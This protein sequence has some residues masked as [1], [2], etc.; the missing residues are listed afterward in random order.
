MRSG[1]ENDRFSMRDDSYFIASVRN[2][3]PIS[4]AK[5]RSIALPL[6][7]PKR[8]AV[9]SMAFSTTSTRSADS[10]ALQLRGK[11]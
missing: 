2:A 11:L 6:H 4:G 3:L 8:K 9:R 7:G 5:H 1:G 10:C